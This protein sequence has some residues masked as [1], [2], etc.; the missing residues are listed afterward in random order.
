[1]PNVR[2]WALQYP[3]AI[4]RWTKNG[5]D[6][7]GNTESIADR[8][9]SQ[10]K[11]KG[12]MKNGGKPC[13]WVCHSLGGLVAKHILL[14]NKR[15]SKAEG[16]FDDT[17]LKGIMFLGTPH[18]GSNKADF[19]QG[20]VSTIKQVAEL[21]EEAV[22][23][24]LSA[25]SGFPVNVLPNVSGAFGHLTKLIED[26]EDRN[27]RLW[28]LDVRFSQ[29]FGE[30]WAKDKDKAL[31]AS[32]VCEGIAMSVP[33]MTIVDKQSADP[34]LRVTSGDEA[35]TPLVLPLDHS[36]LA[37]PSTVDSEL[38]MLL[39]ELLARLP[40]LQDPYASKLTG[41]THGRQ[42][43][44]L[45]HRVAWS[46]ARGRSDQILNAWRNCHQLALNPN[47]ESQALITQ[48][49]QQIVGDASPRACLAG[50]DTVG[51]LLAANQARPSVE[52]ELSDHCD[53][54]VGWLASVCGAPLPYEAARSDDAD[55]LFYPGF[56]SAESAID[57]V[58]VG[59]SHAL[60]KGWPL[61]SIAD[62]RPD[63]VVTSAEIE[64]LRRRQSTTVKIDDVTAFDTSTSVR[65]VLE[66][67]ELGVDVSTQETVQAFAERNST[68]LHQPMSAREAIR[69]KKRVQTRHGEQIGI[70]LDARSHPLH[71][72][73][74]QALKQS[75]LLPILTVVRKAAEDES[76][77]Q[78]ELEQAIQD[79]RSR[80]NAFL[81]TSTVR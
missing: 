36:Q 57:D 9:R 67:W 5:A 10:I 22:K 4:F 66:R 65:Q 71:A 54:I 39:R 35:V 12:L 55:E 29:Y 62:G 49:V 21:G 15:A 64:S 34:E 60:H 43:W 25:L 68:Q 58:L 31:H 75:A 41:L 59:S 11:A 53:E 73:Q 13:V 50:I 78:V 46:L 44:H 23:G 79:Y 33:P 18:R 37:K 2:V 19:G 72:E 28:S 42:A 40:E 45:S 56:L 77:V 70:A 17:L 47:A 30:R 80:R 27:D 74:D 52:R 26:L 48:I 24:Y 7:I 14:K 38:F 6:A 1:M 76:E 20:F 63:R 16:R 81:Y 3:S 8:V 32:V 61:K 69:L 51:L